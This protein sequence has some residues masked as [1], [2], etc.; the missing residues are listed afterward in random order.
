MNSKPL[1][2]GS[3][4]LSI[5]STLCVAPIYVRKNRELDCPQPTSVGDRA[6]ARAVVEA[7]GHNLSPASQVQ[8]A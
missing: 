5:G 6:V 7:L 4:S 8:T 2:L 3:G 1:R